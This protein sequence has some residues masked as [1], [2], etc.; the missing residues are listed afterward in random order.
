[1]HA[2]RKPFIPAAGYHF[3]LRFYDPLT[4]LFGAEAARS[5]VID[6]ARLGA[7]VRAL[8]IGCGTGSLLVAAKQ[9]C[10]GAELVGLDPDLDALARARQKAQAAGATIRFEQGY[11]DELPFEAQ[12]FDR[13]LSSL[14]IHHL[15]PATQD[16]TLAEVARVLE[17]GG[18][19]HILDFTRAHE[20]SHGLWHR[21]VHASGRPAVHV[22]HDLPAALR[23]AGFREV[24]E[25]QQPRMFFQDVT[26]CSATR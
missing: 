7:G 20:R 3:A 14:M 1:M 16:R 22:A 9:R 17:P 25:V 13:V 4:R 23:R 11:S 15:D 19:V 8:D 6:G 26:Y 12:S 24:R 21:F 18:S 2:A 10:P 5:V